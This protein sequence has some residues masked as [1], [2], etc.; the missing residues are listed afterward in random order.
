[1]WINIHFRNFHYPLKMAVVSLMR[2]TGNIIKGY[3]TIFFVVFHMSKLIDDW[4]GCKIF[5]LTFLFIRF[6]RFSCFIFRKYFSNIN[7]FIETKRPA[8]N[9]I[10]YTYWKNQ[11]NW[12][13]LVDLFASPSL[14]C[15]QFEIS[16]FIWFG[17]HTKGVGEKRCLVNW[18][19][20]IL[21]QLQTF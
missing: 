17:N 12:K 8:F 6:F 18:A 9:C 1:M 10:S 20:I 16:H 4:S 5:L 21:K 14:W 7:G 11:L 15:F 2:P 3:G 19:F 13:M